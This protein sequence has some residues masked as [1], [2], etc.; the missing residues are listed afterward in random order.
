LI[1]LRT[2]KLNPPRNTM[3]VM[4]LATRVIERPDLLRDLTNAWAHLK[5]LRR[6]ATLAIS[7]AMQGS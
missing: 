1:N 7:H 4:T 6:Q 2:L 3:S 5:T